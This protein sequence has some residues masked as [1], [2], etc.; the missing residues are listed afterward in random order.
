MS[1]NVAKK[2]NFAAGLSYLNAKYDKTKGGQYDGVIES[3]RP[4]WSGSLLVR[5]NADEKFGAFGR[6]VY[7]GSA[8]VLYEKFWAPSYA[9]FD[10]GIEYKTKIDKLPARFALTCYNL[11]DKSYWMIARG[12]NLYMSTPRTLA[13]SMSVDF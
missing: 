2:W 1:G 8:P 13:L 5:Y 3:G 4:Y 10:L 11:F 12:D 6:M 7:T 9:V